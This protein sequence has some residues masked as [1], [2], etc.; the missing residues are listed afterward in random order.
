MHIQEQRHQK[1]NTGRL[2]CLHLAN[3]EI[4]PGIGFDDV[5]RVRELID[6]PGNYPV[7]LYP[8]ADAIRLEEGRLTPAALDGRRLVVFLLDGTWTL[9]RKSLRDS[10]GLLRL[11]RVAITPR[12]PSRFVIKRQ[13]HP[14]CLSTLEA[15]H[16]LLVALEAA[17]LD[18]YTDHERL[19]A[20][21]D[22]MQRVQIE[23]ARR[24]AN[25]R[26]LTRRS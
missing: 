12:S 17:G 15:T 21:F 18:R 6:D 13:P 19:L 1:S 25:P 2:L 11:P 16:E 23:A 26:R 24:A 4:I 7:L 9:A 20:A 5:P 8:G 14:W 10:P 22:A 3:S